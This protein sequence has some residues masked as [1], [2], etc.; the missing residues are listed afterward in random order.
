MKEGQILG[1]PEKFE[2]I[3]GLI[4]LNIVPYE[5]DVEFFANDVEMSLDFLLLV[6]LLNRIPTFTGGKVGRVLEL[7]G[8][9]DDIVGGE[10]KELK[11][12]GLMF[13]QVLAEID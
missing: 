8:L 10:V 2:S 12:F 4:E 9:K 13:K 1:M 5:P 11:H 6:E 3:K 7:K